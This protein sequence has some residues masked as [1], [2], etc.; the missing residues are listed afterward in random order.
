MFAAH[1]MDATSPRW[2]SIT[3][4]EFPWE[5]EALAFVRERLPDHEPYRAWSNFEFI[6]DDGSINEVDLLVLTPK[7]FYLVEIKSRP[8]LVEGDRGTWTWRRDGR[9]HTIDNP[10]LLANRKARKL[11]SLLRHQ[12]ALTRKTPAPFLEAQVFLSHEDVDCRLTKDLRDRVHLRDSGSGRKERPG[13]VAALTR[14][15][16]GTV[17]RTRPDRP[18]AKAIS[19]AMQEA[20]IRPSQSARRVGDY[21]LRE[22][23][24]EGPNYQDWMAT[25]AAIDGDLARVRIYGM[26]RGASNDARSVLER[27]A[28]REYRILSD[29]R[30]VGILAVK[31]YTEHAGCPTLVFEHSADCQRFDHWLAE[32]AADLDVDTRLDLLRQIADAVRYAHEKHLIHRALSP[33]SILVRNP[34]EVPPRV[35]IFNWQTGARQ[36]SGTSTAGPLTSGATRLDAL[37]EDQAW[38]YMAPE[39]VTERASVGEQCDVF[40]LGAI[41]YHLFAGQP[42]ASS[43]FEMTERLQREQGLQLSSVLDGAGQQLPLLVQRAT[44]PEVTAR[45]ESVREFLDGLEQFEEEITRPAEQSW[46]DPI[47]AR[48]N[49]ELEH[50]FVVRKRLGKG[51]TA[52]A[53]LV[54]CN[55]CEQVL[56]VALSPE[57]NSR[58]ETEAEVLRT[59]RHQ[60]IVEFH[61]LLRFGDRVGLLMARAGDATLA[62][63]LRD[64]GR[65]HLELLERF[66]EDLLTTIDWLEKSG[67]P[68]RDIKPE[69]L[70]TAKIGNQLHLVLFDFSLARTSAENI[71]AGTRDYLD[72]FL[73]TRTPPRWDTYAERFA[74]AVTLYQT[75]A[76]SLPRWGDGQS[77]PAVL[78]CEA[79]IDADAFEP[80][81]RE[82][83][84]A[85]FEKALRRDYGKRFDNAQ[86]MLRAWRQLF[87]AAAR[88]ETVSGDPAPTPSLV[89]IDEAKLDSRLSE[90][91]LSARALSAVERMNVRTVEDLLRFPLIHVNRMRGVGSRTRRDLTELARQLATRFPKAAGKPKAVSTADAETIPDDGARVSVDALLRQLLPAGRTARTKR[92]AEVIAA[93][94]EPR[95]DKPAASWPGQSDVAHALGVTPE[96]VSHAVARA[97]QRWSKVPALTRLRQD[98]VEILE[99][100]GNV[101]TQTELVEAVLASRGSVQEQPLRSRHA[102]ACVRAAVEIENR[103]AVPRWI[104]RRVDS[105]AGVLLARDVIDEDGTRRL[106]GQGLADFARRLGREADALAETDPLPTPARVLDALQRVGAPAGVTMP[107]PN[108]LS[109]LAAAVSRGAALSSRLELYPRGMAANRAL[110]LALGALAGAR[111]L[112][113]EQI[114]A[115]VAGRYPESA[116][117]PD[118]PALDT[119]LQDAGSELVWRPDADNGRGA[120][121]SRFRGFVTVTSGTSHKRTSGQVAG[122]EDWSDRQDFDQR[123]RRVLDD[124]GF[125][126][127]TV[128]AHRLAEA[129]HALASAF[130]IDP[131]SLDELLIRHMKAAAAE[132]GA[133]W[134]VILRADRE[135]RGSSD[136]TNLLRLVAHRALPR[137]RDEMAA[138]ERPVLL[139]N[140]GLLARY[141]QMAFLD[142]LRDSAGGRDGPPGVWL[143]VPSDP[144]ESRPLIDGKPVPVFTAAQWARLPGAWLA[145][146][147]PPERETAALS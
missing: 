75:A 124:R 117:L 132:A 48:P 13:I 100:H 146:R 50:G 72:P 136:W 2:Q 81:V 104:V 82:G 35:Q 53:L 107:A 125:L 130:S 137:V 56:K 70:G 67:I 106:D 87:L 95:D 36:A 63:R 90:L 61:E 24:L 118:R 25:H 140:L 26:P 16:A 51:S 8:G 86:E 141:D 85:F 28:R 134:Q 120:Y 27:A 46:P 131:R 92:D 109:S 80:A 4:S 139:T 12:P 40:S 116:R 6:A 93:F 31:T 10:L 94:L 3:D 69:N 111:T 58:L 30:H 11:I 64:E 9:A 73:Q 122:T 115:R 7:G 113:P 29:I 49:D 43:L 88:P 44:C 119:L 96:A 62:D 97:C 33:Q 19:R 91:G 55:G 114:R 144:Q 77:E 105:P 15:S 126:A 47:N 142:G 17:L 129:E 22:L 79:T 112:N 101:L 65:L 32:R 143:L 83:L 138:A 74:A 20:G 133:D 59:L 99:A 108:R 145:G 127:I 34:A 78:D 98:I 89:P 52:L 38:V 18:M 14:H 23:L 1:T 71:L 135:P 102:R 37:V 76:G 57:D 54:E 128:P 66:G 5:R 60:Y 21:R 147:K 110:K 121:E 68:H 42:P 123:L 41:A 45:L 39:A 103:L 84:T